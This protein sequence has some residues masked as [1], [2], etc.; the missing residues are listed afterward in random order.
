MQKSKL[1]STPKQTEKGARQLKQPKK[2]GTTNSTKQHNPSLGYDTSTPLLKIA[3]TNVVALCKEL[4]SVLT[5]LDALRT[6]GYRFFQ[7]PGIDATLEQASFYEGLDKITQAVRIKQAKE[8]SHAFMFTGI[9]GEQVHALALEKFQKV[10]D[11]EQRYIVIQ[12]LD[13]YGHI[14]AEYKS[15]VDQQLRDEAEAAL[16]GAAGKKGK[17]G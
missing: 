6:F 4:T 9:G 16:R 14:P 17:R 13:K 12:F 10:F 1:P 3:E 8:I 7:G 5:M 11:P 15:S 2:L